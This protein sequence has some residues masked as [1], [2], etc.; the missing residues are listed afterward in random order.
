MDCKTARLL[1]DFH[2]PRAGELAADEAADL[3]R[4]LGCCPECDAAARAG[5][6][7]DDHLGLAVRDV[8]VPDKLRERL[9]AR[10][11]GERQAALRRKLAWAAR[12][13]AV[14]AALLIGVFVWWQYIGSKPPRLELDPLT[15]ADIAKHN[16]RTPEQV[17]V[18]FQEHHQITMVAPKDFDYRFLADY[19]LAT[20]QGKPVPKLVFQRSENNGITRARVFVLT[21]EQFD[22]SGLPTVPPDIQSLGRWLTVKEPPEAPNTRYLIIYEG[23]NGLDPLIDKDKL[24][25]GA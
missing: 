8:P 7:L 1:L 12:G 4:H 18:W 3:E 9:L 21:R 6:R 2:R 22:L 14:A 10:L 25:Q 20:L 17:E 19:E 16:S 13:A 11:K 5:R 23:D 15:E 24:P